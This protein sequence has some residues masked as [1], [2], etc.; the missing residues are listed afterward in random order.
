[1]LRFINHHLNT[2]RYL[3]I[4]FWLQAIDIHCWHFHWN[5]ESSHCPFWHGWENHC[6]S[7]SSQWGVNFYRHQ[8]GLNILPIV[9]NQR[10]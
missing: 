1:M 3:K 10:I 2:W 8:S 5:N 4:K 9:R 6:E 7:E